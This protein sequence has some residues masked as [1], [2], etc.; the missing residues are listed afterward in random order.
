MKLLSAS[1]R[2]SSRYAGAYMLIEAMVYVGALFVL[3]GAGY[4]AVYRCID[5]SV[6]LRRNA[7][8]IT[9]ALQTG[10][11]WRADVR[12]ATG[13]ARLD[14][15]EAGQLLHLHGQRTEHQYKFADG[16]VWRRS[17]DG[18]WVSVL[19][20]VI[21]SKIESDRRQKVTALRWE[22][23]LRSHSRLSQ[24][25]PLFTFLAAPPAPPQ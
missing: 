6:A 23:E 2:L 22:L 4:A 13:G 20:N 3:L 7:E 8:D 25:K 10:E 17:G 11:R 21:S 19:T 15:A 1:R 5:R 14:N 16:A 18:P 12:L 24:I 9:S